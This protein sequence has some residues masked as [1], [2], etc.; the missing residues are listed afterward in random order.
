MASL[1]ALSVG[2]ELCL[3]QAACPLKVQERLLDLVPTEDKSVP[4]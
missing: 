3:Q 2:N 1:F 4:R